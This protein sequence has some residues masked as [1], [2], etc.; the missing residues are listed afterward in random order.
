[1]IRQ[2]LKQRMRKQDA[3]G[4][5]IARAVERYESQKG[6]LYA[7]KHYRASM[8]RGRSVKAALEVIAM[9]WPEIA[10]RSEEKPVFILSAGW[11]SG[12]TMLQRLVMSREP[13]LIWG[14]PYSHALMLHHL[15]DGLSAITDDWPE[16]RWFVGEYDLDKLSTTFVANLYPEV[17]DLHN[18]CLAY[19]QA[20]FAGPAQTR[21]YPRWGIKDVRLDIDDARF[22]QWL[23]PQA[24]FLFLVRNPYAAYRSY[25][26]ARNWYYEWPDDPVLTA[27][28]FGQHWRK[29]AGGFRDEL[30]EVGGMLLRQEDIAGGDVDFDAL[31][32]YLEL[33]IDPQLLGE[34]VG[35][36]RTHGDRVPAQEIRMLAAQVEPMAESFGYRPR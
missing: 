26:L 31:Q 13:V 19:M 17:Q 20:L 2:F 5:L 10:S 29:L 11:R 24:K 6:T 22:L 35:S 14:E 21:G 23:Y 7:Q 8:A 16:Q 3:L 27:K 32:T 12:S 34:K 25:R 9:R 28:R 30:D 1:M 36:H 15:S 33:E 4:R 18:A